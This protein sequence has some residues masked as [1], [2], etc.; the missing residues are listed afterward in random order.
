MGLSAGS[1]FPHT[2]LKHHGKTCVSLPPT[3]ESP[4]SQEEQRKGGFW[5]LSEGMNNHHSQDLQ[6]QLEIVQNQEL[7]CF[8]SLHHDI[9]TQTPPRSQRCHCVSGHWERDEQGTGTFSCVSCAQ[10]EQAALVFAVG[11]RDVCLKSSEHRF[12]FSHHPCGVG[13]GGKPQEEHPATSCPVIQPE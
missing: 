4:K 9:P 11:H 10:G 2:I 12:L 13:Q 6:Y 1:K 7:H 8:F 5:V 3:G